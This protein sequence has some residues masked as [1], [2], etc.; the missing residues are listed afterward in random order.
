[1]PEIIVAC[2]LPNGHIIAVGDKSVRLNGSSSAQRNDLNPEQSGFGL[3]TVDAEFYRAW[4]KTH[5]DAKYAPL[6]AGLIFAHEKPENT[7][8]EA[9][10]KANVKT[11]F[12]G[13]P[14][15]GNGIEPEEETAK[16]RRAKG[17]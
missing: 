7:R 16:A 6:M 10:E 4:E 14:Q 12:E 2:K 3:T 11:G 15:E 17:K 1:M 5:R 8:A 9:A 13:L